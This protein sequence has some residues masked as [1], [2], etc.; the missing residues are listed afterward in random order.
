MRWR[1]LDPCRKNRLI[2]CGPDRKWKILEEGLEAGWAHD[3]LPG[4]VPF[5]PTFEPKGSFEARA[6]SSMRL[7]IPRTSPSR[8]GI[9]R[10]YLI[11]NFDVKLLATNPGIQPPQPAIL[12]RT[13]VLENHNIWPRTTGCGVLTTYG[14]WYSSEPEGQRPWCLSY[15]KSGSPRVLYQRGGRLGDAGPAFL[16]FVK[17]SC[18]FKTLLSLGTGVLLGVLAGRRPKT[19]WSADTVPGVNAGMRSDGYRS[20]QCC[21]LKSVSCTDPQY[22]NHSGHV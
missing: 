7:R 15:N 2:T 17:F 14:A 12:P 6:A 13:K 22:Q 4:L 16:K 11:L 9:W 21:S 19:V 20:P 10:N 5:V 1:K 18:S 8:W 3:Q